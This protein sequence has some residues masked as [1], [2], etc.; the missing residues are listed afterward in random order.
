V[1]GHTPLLSG[2]AV[3]NSG[4][5]VRI[6]SGNSRAYGGVPGYVEIV[7]DQVTI[8]QVARPSAR[9]LIP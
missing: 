3:T 9:R 5:L 2:V 8:H 6:D 1:I 4:R 7:G